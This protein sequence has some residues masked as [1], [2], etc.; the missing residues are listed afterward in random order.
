MTQLYKMGDGRLGEGNYFDQ[1]NNS[2]FGRLSYYLPFGRV[3]LFLPMRGKNLVTDTD[4][5]VANH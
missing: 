1:K 5:I 2:V 3:K 4:N